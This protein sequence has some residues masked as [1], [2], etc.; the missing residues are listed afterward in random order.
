MLGIMLARAMAGDGGLDFDA[1][2]DAVTVAAPASSETS[3]AAWATVLALSGLCALIGWTGRRA[4]LSD[5]ALRLASIAVPARLAISC[6]LVIYAVTHALGA[7]AVYLQTRVVYGSATEYFQYL[8]PARLAS[9]SHAHLMG[10]ATMQ[11]AVAILY[12]LSRRDGV[13]PRLAV[14]LAFAGVFGDIGSWWLIKYVSPGWDVVATFAGSSCALSY[15][16]MATA[17]LGDL[18][19]SRT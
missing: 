2:P 4:A 5:P 9:M 16:W 18:W 14:S 3:Y 8:Q 10:I 6:T 1:V 12:G 7:L 19:R 17:V 13:V 11:G 15:A